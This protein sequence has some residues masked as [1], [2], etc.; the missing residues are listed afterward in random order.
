MGAMPRCA[1][2]PPTLPVREAVSALPVLKYIASAHAALQT[3]QGGVPGDAGWLRA[4]RQL[5]AINMTTSLWAV[6]LPAACW[7]TA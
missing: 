3:L 7:P 4:P 6:A 1:L 5:L 2:A